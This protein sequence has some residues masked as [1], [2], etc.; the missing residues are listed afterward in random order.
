MNQKELSIV[1]RE[2]ARSQK[3]RLCDVW[4]SEWDDDSD[5]DALLDKFVRGHDFCITN[6]YPSLP[7]IREHLLRYRDALHRHHIYV[8]ESVDLTADN[9]TYIFLGACTGRLVARGLHT[10]SVYC[11]HESVLDVSA[12]EGSNVFVSTYERS[13]VICHAD[14]MSLLHHYRR[15]KQE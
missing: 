12:L 14:I 8:D 9:G 11:R 15:E 7:F 1:L 4:Y 2:L 6:D 10:V 3:V 13:H 5:I